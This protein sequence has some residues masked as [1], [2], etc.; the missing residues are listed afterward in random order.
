MDGSVSKNYKVSQLLKNRILWRI[1]VLWFFR[2]IMPL[3][4]LQVA[5]FALALKVF[6]RYVFVSKVFRNAA[7]MSEFSYWDVLKFIYNAFINT[8]PLTQVVILIILGVVALLIRDLVRALLTYRSMWLRDRRG[9][10]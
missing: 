5:L 1:Y 9:G 2:R 8:H 6:A 7:L 3:I 10:A 4:V